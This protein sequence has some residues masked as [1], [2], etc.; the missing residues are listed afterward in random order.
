MLI[1]L[2]IVGSTIPAAVKNATASGS[3]TGGGGVGLLGQGSN[4]LYGAPSSG[5]GAGSGGSAGANPVA[6]VKYGGAG[7][8]YGGGGGAGNYNFYSYGSGFGGDGA[9]GAVRIIWAGTGPARAF[10]STNTGN[11]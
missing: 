5:G 6:G 1:A 10:P 7:G 4:G 8:N 9:V 3:R 2:S 11:L